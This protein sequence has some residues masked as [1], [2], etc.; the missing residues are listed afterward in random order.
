M[1]IEIF[2]GSVSDYNSGYA[3]YIGGKTVLPIVSFSVGDP[4]TNFYYLSFSAQPLAAGEY[5][6]VACKRSF[7]MRGTR[8]ALAYRNLGDLGSAHFMDV[9][10][11][12]VFVLFGALGAFG[13]IFPGPLNNGLKVLTVGL[14]A[15]GAFGLWRLWSMRR[16]C[17]MLN[18]LPSSLSTYPQRQ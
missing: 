5:V 6:A 4:P 12:I 8:A 15:L 18:L 16:A 13:G 2:K 7:V 11:P 9:S 14:L 3:D 10:F 17:R 1:S